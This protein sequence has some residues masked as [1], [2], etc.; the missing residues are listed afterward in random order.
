MRIS[1]TMLLLLFAG[2]V[3]TVW[4]QSV[5]SPQTITLSQAVDQAIKTGDTFAQVGANLSAAQATDSLAQAKNSFTVTGS[6][7]YGASQSANNPA[8]NVSTAPNVY[9]SNGQPFP[10]GVI[11]TAT[12]GSETTDGVLVQNPTA[13]VTAG[14]PMTTIT[15]SWSTGYQSWPTDGSI[16]NVGIGSFKLNQ[17]IWDGYWGGPTQAAADKAGYGYQIAQLNARASQSSAVL[18]VKQAYFTMQSAQENLSVLKDTA[19]S[20]EKT[21]EITQAR[22]AQQVATDVDVLTARVSLQNAQLDLLAGQNALATARKRL[23]NLMGISPDTA[24]QV[25]LEPD[26]T[27]PAKNLE[28]A[29]NLGLKN[30]VEI[31]IADLNAKSS[32]VDQNLALGSGTPSVAVSGGVTN[33]T[34]MTASRST[35]VGQVG[36]SLGAP[37]WDA[38]AASSSAAQA[39]KTRQAYLSQVHQLRQSIP[40]DIQ[41][42]WNN[43]QVDLQRLDVAVDNKKAFDQQLEIARVQFQLGTKTLSD[44]LTAQTNASTADFGLLNAKIT[45]QLAALQL[46]NLLGL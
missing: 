38:G 46:Q 31:Q 17:T 34:D 4:C 45:A 2:S 24:F 6:I 9:L 29:V 12:V 27:S 23:A 33:Y 15:G 26:P 39:D 7:G 14:T 37:L 28:E 32:L 22:F 19:D 5:G 44:V 42:G 25:S 13:S 30:R 20:W 40:V 3:G 1:K 11:P 41:E 21:L 8:Q 43:W 35:L 18:A 16:R 10:T 36:V